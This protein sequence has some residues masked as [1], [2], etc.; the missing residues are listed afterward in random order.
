MR[1]QPTAAGLEEGGRRTHAMKCGWPLDAAKGKETDSPLEPS[2][3]NE[4]FQHLDVSLVR[5]VSDFWPT[6]LR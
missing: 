2:E 6:E 4:P 5:P 3:R 1:T